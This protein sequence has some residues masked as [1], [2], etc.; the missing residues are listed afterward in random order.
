MH[1]CPSK[2]SGEIAPMPVPT[3]QL[4]KQQAGL[5]PS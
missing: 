1:D 5:S 2:L 4:I 3:Y